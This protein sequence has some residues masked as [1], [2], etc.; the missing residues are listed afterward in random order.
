MK[1]VFEHGVQNDLLR[2]LDEVV[3]QTRLERLGGVLAKIL[4]R[5]SLNPMSYQNQWRQ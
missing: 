5:K 1:G 3:K 2:P 4:L